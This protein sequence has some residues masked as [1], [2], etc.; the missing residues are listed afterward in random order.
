[1]KKRLGMAHV[2]LGTDGGGTLP[3]L[4]TG[5]ADIR[6]L[7]KLAAAMA[8]AGLSRQDTAAY[9]GGNFYRVLKRCLG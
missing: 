6:D 3:R 1:M 7:P 9:M 5:Y 4:I 8:Q 2:G